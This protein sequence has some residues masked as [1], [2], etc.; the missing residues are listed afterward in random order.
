MVRIWKMNKNNMENTS[1]IFWYVSDCW[2]MARR[3]I[4]HIMRSLDQ[5]MSVAMFPV[6]FMLLNR[7]V[8]GGAID[9]GE[10]SY[11]N[12]LFAGIFVQTLAF[13]ANYTTINLAVDLQQ[14]IIDRFRSLPMNSSAL[15]VGHVIADL[16]RNLVS[17]VVVLLVGFLVGFRPN[18]TVG[19]WLAVLGLSILFTLAIS[20]MSAILGLMVKS[21]EAAQWVGFVVIFPL[22]FISSAFVPTETMPRMLR[23]FAE[24][25]PLSQVMNAMRSWLVGTPMENAAWA[26]VLWCLALIAISVPITTWLF[27]RKNR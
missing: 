18:A 7:Y 5:L 1:Q 4:L 15:V 26:A 25:Q 8:L 14:G 16:L 9:T 20:W 10:I 21:L 23:L 3:S 17:G 24:N 12:Y 6:M 22:T 13:G 11:A 19:E 2:I 27:R